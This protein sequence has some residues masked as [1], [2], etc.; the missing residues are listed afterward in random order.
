MLEKFSEVNENSFVLQLILKKK[1]I[2][3][4]TDTEWE[5]FLEHS[6]LAMFRAEYVIKKIY[7]I[8]RSGVFTCEVTK[9][10]LVKLTDLV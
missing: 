3:N 1:I 5:L 2:I 7:I 6:L 8:I 10:K 9:G 4:R